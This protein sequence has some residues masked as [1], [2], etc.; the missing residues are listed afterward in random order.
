[1]PNKDLIAW[2]SMLTGY[3]HLGL[4]QEALSLFNSMRVNNSKPDDFTFTSAM[5]ACAGSFELCHGRKLHALIIVLGYDYSVP[6]S[7]S[8]IDMYGKCL[9]PCCANRVFEGMGLKN[10]VSWCSLLFAYMNAAQFGNGRSVFEAM[11][12][13]V[14]IAWNTM[15]ASYAR[16]GEIE[17]CFEMFKKMLENSCC[18]DQWTF[19]AL[20]NACAEAQQFRNGCIVHAF[21]VK[22]GWSSAVEVNNSNLSFYARLSGREDV[23]KVFKSIRTVSQVSWNAIIDAHMKI[24][25]TQEAFLAFKQAPEKNVVSWTSMITGYARNG[26]GEKAIFY[27]ADMLRNGLQPDHFT[28][29][30]VLHACSNWA[31]LGHGKMVHGCAIHCGFHGYVYITNGLV[32]MYAKCGDLEGSSRAFSYI[33]EKDLISWNTMLFAY[34]LHGGAIQVLQ[35]HEDM[36]SSGFEPD[37][38]TFIG[39]LMS[40]SHSGLIEKGRAFF[41]S[42]SSV[43][44]LT[45][46]TDHVACM[47]DMLGRGGYLDEARELANKYLGMHSARI[48]SSEALFGAY[49]AQADIGMGAGLGEE[50]Q[51]LEPQ[52]EMSYVLL[53]NLYCASGQWKSAEMVRKAMADQGVKKIPGC[54]W[55]GVG[56]EV[57]AFVAGRH[58]QPYMEELCK[59][60]NFL[61]HEMGNPSSMV[62]IGFT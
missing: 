16:C 3:C 58:S 47:V 34:G 54:S 35:L 52:N 10:E 48:S 33:L 37:K 41:E 14:E 29:G 1:M 62:G 45:P 9:S 8:L 21:I 42:M 25:D 39:L 51:I 17:M 5:N 43:Y 61:E 36:I 40:C 50:L 26:H 31:T 53:S 56:T 49:S 13:R 57:A 55:I 32:N 38:V 20:M 2:N 4:H 19:S 60:L 7:N 15:I 44:G 18:P 22:S 27:F 30:A 12:K 11:P 23:V 24:G 46:E 6:V 28:F 59:I